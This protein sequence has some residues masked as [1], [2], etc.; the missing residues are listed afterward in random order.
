MNPNLNPNTCIQARLAERECVTKD[1]N[2]LNK[3]FGLL[4][5]R[6]L[7]CKIWCAEWVSCVESQCN[8]LRRGSTPVQSR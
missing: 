6:S 8:N 1:L 5:Q 2:A 3:R 7:M 4:V